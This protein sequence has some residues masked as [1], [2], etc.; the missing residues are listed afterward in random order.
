M[1]TNITKYVAP[2]I[3]AVYIPMCAAHVKPTVR[4]SEAA[5]TQLW[6]KPQDLAARDL[7]D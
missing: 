2:G 7:L 5:M 1:L 3:F 4:P 6:E